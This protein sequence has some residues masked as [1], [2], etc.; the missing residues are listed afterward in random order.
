M[1]VPPEH[2]ANSE[3]SYRDQ[4]DNQSGSFDPCRRRNAERHDDPEKTDLPRKDMNTCGK[5]AERQQHENGE[6]GRA[7]IENPLDVR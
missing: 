1:P 7:G 3:R 5:G 6:P 2:D 4:H